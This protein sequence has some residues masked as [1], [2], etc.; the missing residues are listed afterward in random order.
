MLETLYLGIGT[1]ILVCVN[2]ALGSISAL[3]NKEWNWTIFR[4][5]LIKGAVVVLAFAAVWFVGW[6][7]KDLA[8]VEVDGQMVNLQMA[9][10]IILTGGFAVYAGKV[11]LKLKEIVI[12]KAVDYGSGPIQ[13]KIEIF[14]T[15]AKTEK[16]PVG[17]TETE[18]AE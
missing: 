15:E 18:K 12:K 14:E 8:A 3:M 5:G 7:N 13:P 6:L 10:H 9:V 17:E 11:L 1:L 4:N 16:A 2:I